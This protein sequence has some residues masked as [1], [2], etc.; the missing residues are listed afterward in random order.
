MKK[1]LII[2]HTWEPICLPDIHADHFRTSANHICKALGLI[3]F[4]SFSLAGFQGLDICYET[5]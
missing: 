4:V 1:S 5:R 3:T 2:G